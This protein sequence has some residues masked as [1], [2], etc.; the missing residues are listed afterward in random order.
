MA[1]YSWPLYPITSFCQLDFAFTVSFFKIRNNDLRNY[2]KIGIT[3]KLVKL[4]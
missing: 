4:K 2:H 1:L 3:A